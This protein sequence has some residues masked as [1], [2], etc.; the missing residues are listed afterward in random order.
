[1]V[2]I[3]N[4]A[5]VP[6][7]QGKRTNYALDITCGGFVFNEW[8]LQEIDA[9]EVSEQLHMGNDVPF[10]LDSDVTLEDGSIVK[11]YVTFA[12]KSSSE[13]RSKLAARRASITAK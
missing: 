2:N 7:E 12:R 3:V 1:M 4:K 5:Q 6:A 10:T 8:G 13:L 9:K 11:S